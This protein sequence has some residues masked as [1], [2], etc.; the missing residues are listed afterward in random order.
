MR[1]GKV[2]LLRFAVGISGSSR[3]I[4]QTEALEK[5]GIVIELAAVPQAHAKIAADGPRLP[6]LR[7]RRK[8]VRANIGRSKARITLLDVSGLPVHL[9]GIGYGVRCRI[10]LSRRGISTRP[11]QL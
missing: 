9:E 5:L 6:R 7:P 4:V 11:A 3:G 1:I 10:F 2:G 8:A